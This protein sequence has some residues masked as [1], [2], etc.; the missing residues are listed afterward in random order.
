MLKDRKYLENELVLIMVNNVANTTGTTPHQKWCLDLLDK[1][2]IPIAIGSDIIST[3]KD[4]SEYNDFILFAVT[5]IIKPKRISEYFTPQEIEMYYDRKYETE[6]VNKFPMKFHLIMVK[7]DQYIG[8]IDVK[9]LMRLREQQLINYN[10]D[11]QRALRIMLKGGTKILR[12]YVDNRAVSEIEQCFN[13]DNFIPNV[14]TLNINL[15]DENADYVYNDK[16]ETLIIKNLTAFDI[17]DGYHRY[18]AIGR[19]YDKNDSWNFPMELRI[20]MFSVGKARQFIY[21]E[22]HKTKMKETDAKS[23]DQQNYGNL[24]TTR[25][26]TETDSY[27][28]GNVNI[29]GGIVD[30]G[31][32]SQVINRLY[33]SKNVTRKDVIVTGKELQIKLNKFCEENDEYFD[34]KWKV[35]EIMMILYGIHE[36][37]TPQ[38][39][40]A[41][42]DRLSKED[43]E[44]LNRVK[45]IKVKSLNIM[46]EVY[47]ND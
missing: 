31:V 4:L 22:N 1:Y 10:A 46:K 12:P 34:H 23:Y 14:I 30:A 16:N 28:K 7:E 21:Q 6:T 40:K 18:L 35:Y 37:Y 27:L 32:M 20:T 24:V 15:D 25:L 3:R 38:Q 44:T 17:V 9:T 11:T 41:A 43:K 42:I 19:K 33:F 47:H 2:N 13:T 36:D 8:K 29:T 5:D 45:D 26:N 39:I